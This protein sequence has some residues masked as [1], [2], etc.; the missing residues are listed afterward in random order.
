M[1]KIKNIGIVTHYYKSK[2]FGGNLQAYALT[3]FIN[4]LDNYSAEQI[5]YSFI[6]SENAKHTYEHCQRRSVWKKLIFAIIHPIPYTKKALQVLQSFF[7]PEAIKGR[8]IT[9][10]N[11]RYYSR[12]L[13][14]NKAIEY[15]N[16][17]IIPH[18]DFVYDGK[19]INDSNKRYDI[20]ITGSD[21]VW[22]GC[23]NFFMLGFAKNKIKLSYAASI[24]RKEISEKHKKYL[25]EKIVDY[26]A[27]SVRDQTDKRIV[28]EITDKEVRIVLDPVFLLSKTDWDKIATKKFNY[29]NKY[30]FCYFLGNSKKYKK[31]VKRF[32]KNNE[33]RIVNIAHFMDNQNRFLFNDL[34]FGNYK[35]FDVSPAVFI[36][37]IKN[38]EYVFTDSFHAVVFSII[39]HKE[40]YCFNRNSQYGDMSSRIVNLLNNYDLYARFCY[41][42]QKECINYIQSLPQ[43]NYTLTDKLLM[44]DIQ[45][46]K[47]FLLTNLK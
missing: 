23:S 28:S 40:F 9:L 30:L 10:I 1:I 37:L 6:T 31:I 34:F 3:A 11:N 7:S 22:S 25:K 20:F 5:C 46:S 43:I 17:N 33:L 27:I 29:P 2:N 26:K 39:Y 14:R 38:A 19:S 42:E 35:P 24:A 36:S 21:Q 12:F 44:M 47:E 41:G 4:N 8:F 16:Q 45:N 18:S 32:A 13:E 15:F